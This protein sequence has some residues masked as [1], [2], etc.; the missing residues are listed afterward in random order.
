MIT[1]IEGDFT[2]APPRCIL[3]HQ[4]N[5]KVLGPILASALGSKYRLMSLAFYAKASSESPLGLGE[6]QLVLADPAEDI[7][8]ANCCGQIT[9]KRGSVNTQE[10]AVEIYLR[11]LASISKGLNLPVLIPE[12]I[13]SGMGGGNPEHIKQLIITHFRAPEIQCYL[14]DY[15]AKK[16]LKLEGSPLRL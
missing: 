14:V 16:P 11:R 12:G 8:I 5:P 1:V 3:A 6:I 7:Y 2:L 9:T 10:G 4:V 13:G 15:R